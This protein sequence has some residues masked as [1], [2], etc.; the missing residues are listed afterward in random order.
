M[1]CVRSLIS[2][3]R[4]VPVSPS[5]TESQ[6]IS[7][8]ADASEDSLASDAAAS[9]E[10][11]SLEAASLEAASVSA[12]ALDAAVDVPDELLPH[13][14]RLSAVAAASVTA[15]TFFK[16]I[17]DNLLLMSIS[18]PESHAQE[19]VHLFTSLVNL[20][21]INSVINLIIA[22]NFIRSLTIIDIYIIILHI[23]VILYIYINYIYAFCTVLLKL[24]NS[25]RH[26]ASFFCKPNLFHLHAESVK[27]VP[28]C[29]DFYPTFSLTYRKESHTDG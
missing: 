10:A 12:A 7:P 4:S 2:T 27:L 14:A 13:A 1:R 15:V 3:L 25:F 24:K 28:F 16:F 18:A 11:A 22:F 5:V 20:F 23:V 9:L 29:Y 19:P 21:L 17:A 6:V 8:D 26:L